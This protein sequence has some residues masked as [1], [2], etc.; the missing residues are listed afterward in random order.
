MKNYDEEFQMKLKEQEEFNE[1]DAKYRDRLIE[2][3]L[4]DDIQYIKKK[5]EMIVNEQETATF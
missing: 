5:S 1:L 2:P 4:G 3:R